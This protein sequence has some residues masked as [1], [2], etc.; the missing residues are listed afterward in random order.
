M[1][2]EVFEAKGTVSKEPL[3]EKTLAHY[4]N[5]VKFGVGVEVLV[6]GAREL[7]MAKL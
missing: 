2:T 3:E 7:N 5:P 4:G 1:K 6:A